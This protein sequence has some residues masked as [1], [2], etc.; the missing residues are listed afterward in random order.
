MLQGVVASAANG[1]ARRKEVTSMPK[2]PWTSSETKIE[3]GREYLAMASALPLQ[4]FSSTIRFMR[5]V[6]AIRKQLRTADGLVGY[7]LWAKPFS[8]RYWTL[9]V[10]RD[11][12][13]LRAFMRTEPHVH[14][15]ED[16]RPRMGPTRFVFWKVS[17]EQTTPS[18][19]EALE[20]LNAD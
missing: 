6:M 9:S 10:W 14:V 5:Y 11:E 3:A 2:L 12:E 7:A 16:L 15:M 4:R 20:H 13:A 1:C 8:K 18:W 17:D 19:A